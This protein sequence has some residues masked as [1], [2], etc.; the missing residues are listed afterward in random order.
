M[1]VSVIKAK[2]SFKM[3]GLSFSSNLSWGSYIVSIA[4]TAFK[5]IELNLTE[6][7]SVFLSPEV[8]FSLYQ[9]TIPPCMENCYHVRA[10]ALSC[11]L[12]MLDKLQK[13]LRRT[14][15]PTLAASFEPLTHYRSARP[16]SRS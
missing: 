13:R 3:V 8:G 15:A 4:K 11:L 6:L 5:K 1:N 10:G 16:F 2:I 12:D 9:T 7:K 14:V